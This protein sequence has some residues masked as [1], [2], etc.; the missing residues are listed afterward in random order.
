MNSKDRFKK[1]F[2]FSVQC[3]FA[4]RKYDM[5]LKLSTVEK[6]FAEQSNIQEF[7]SFTLKQP[8]PGVIV[9]SPAL[10]YRWAVTYIRLQKTEQYKYQDSKYVVELSAVSEHVLKD[11]T[12]HV[13]TPQDFNYRDEIS[14]RKT[15]STH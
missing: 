13:I 9:Y 10:K 12:H 6:P 4:H 1:Y 15:Q 7:M 5:R 14:V 3:E 11:Q 2:F 8:E